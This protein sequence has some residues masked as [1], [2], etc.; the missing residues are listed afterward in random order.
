M[1]KRVDIESYRSYMKYLSSAIDEDFSSISKIQSIDFNT[2][3]DSEG[4]KIK[5]DEISHLVEDLRERIEEFKEI[6]S[7]SQSRDGK[8]SKLGI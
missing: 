7:L 8:I 3:C 2:N 1:P 6:I 4:I 5:T